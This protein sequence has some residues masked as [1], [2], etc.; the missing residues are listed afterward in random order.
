MFVSL[1]A[2]AAANL[3][4]KVFISQSLFLIS[5]IASYKCKRE[6]SEIVSVIFMMHNYGDLLCVE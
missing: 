3:S 6:I 5:P 4:P 2:L 1:P